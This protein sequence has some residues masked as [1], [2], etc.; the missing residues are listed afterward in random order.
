MRYLLDT[1][2]ISELRKETCNLVVRSAIEKI[3]ATDLYLSV[4][5][6]G[7]IEAG[8]QK[9]SDSQ[10]K[11]EIYL[12]LHD[13]LPLC[14]EDRIIPITFDVMVTWGKLCATSK[15]TLPIMDSL[16]AATAITYSTVLLTR[17]IRDFENIKELELIN[18]WE[19]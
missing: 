1:N 14:F 18:P 2:V 5:S 10:K 13:K 6:I 19:T 11:L 7:E 8:V 9:L 3:D 16:I 17:N 12:W 4:I 15:K